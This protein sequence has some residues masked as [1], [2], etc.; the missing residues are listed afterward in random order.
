MTTKLR[1]LSPIFQGTPEFRAEYDPAAVGWQRT[2]HRIG[3]DRDGEFALRG[4]FSTL[5]ELF[6]G[7]LGNHITEFETAV[8]WRGFVWSMTLNYQGVSRRVSYDKIYNAVKANFKRLVIN[9]GFETDGG[10]PPVAANWSEFIAGGDSITA[11][12]NL[13]FVASGARA[14]ELVNGGGGSSNISQDIEGFVPHG[15]YRISFATRGD[16]TVGGQYAIYDVVNTG[17]MVEQVATDVISTGYRRITNEL[18]MP[19]GCTTVRLYLFVPSATGSAWYDDVEVA[20]V[21]LD[22]KVLGNTT[23]FV[24]NPES[25]A[26]YGRRELIYDAGDVAFVQALSLR[27]VK[28][29]EVA[30]P[31]LSVPDISDDTAESEEAV[32]SVECVGYW[33]TAFFKYM[34]LSTYG[35]EATI[36]DVITSLLTDEC[37]WLTITQIVA[38]AALVQVDSK[39]EQIVGDVLEKL[40]TERYRLLVGV[41][42]G[43]VYEPIDTVPVLYRYGGT[44]TESPG[45]MVGVDGWKVQPGIVIKD[46]DWPAVNTRFEGWL[47]DSSLFVAGEWE[48]SPDG[49]LKL[50]G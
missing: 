26:R 40:I 33:A 29:T 30:W 41:G 42:Q 35:S 32:L 12:T 16:G 23:A 10:S 39:K 19:E 50:R 4:D 28:L 1:V 18:T 37:D 49:R 5:S 31:L 45:A 2:R 15:V 7:W 46:S 9:G 38:N 25:I 14:I 34:A 43:V 17:Y 48:V 24:T 27:T 20:P 8:P 36:S 22:G 3:G 6:N 47:S 44:Y 21:S 11:E 13:D